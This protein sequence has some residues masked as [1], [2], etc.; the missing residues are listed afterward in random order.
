MVVAMAAWRRF[1]HH[2]V[3]HTVEMA[4]A[5]I[6][7]GVLI[8]GAYW[9][10]FMSERNLPGWQHTMSVLCGPECLVMFY[11]TSTTTPARWCILHTLPEIRRLQQAHHSASGV[12]P[13]ASASG[14]DPELGMPAATIERGERHT[15]Q[16][17]SY[18]GVV[19]RMSA[20]HAQ[21]GP[22]HRHS[23]GHRIPS[24]SAIATVAQQQICAPLGLGRSSEIC[25]HVLFLPRDA[26][27]CAAEQALDE[28]DA[29]C[30]TM[31]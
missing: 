9:I 13:D 12:S 7:V 15:S 17:H 26:A 1:R 24:Q 27:R 2:P 18:S 14:N 23:V 28:H 5:T 10:G 6:C 19:L 8:A 29:R 4:G 30:M 22:C 25:A 21:I 3:R 11:S 16:G 31:R 20:R